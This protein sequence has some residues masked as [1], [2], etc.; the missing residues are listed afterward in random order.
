MVIDKLNFFTKLLGSFGKRYIFN[1]AQK[2][3]LYTCGLIVQETMKIFMDIYG[4]YEIG[5]EEFNEALATG[6]KEMI[7]DMLDQSYLFGKGLG[8]IV[9]RTPS[10]S[11]SAIEIGFWALMGKES[12]QL[13]E[14]PIWVPFEQPNEYIGKLVVGIKRCPFCFGMD[15]N[16]ESKLTK[17]HYGDFFAIM[18]GGILQEIMEYV[19]NDFEMISKETKCFMR[20]DEKGELTIYFKQRKN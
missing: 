6:V 18:I 4:D 10:D 16:I 1:T 11:C 13:I 19:G 3:N 7:A 2:I 17:V 12:K 20:G 14:K 9:S 5:I 15:K 8:D